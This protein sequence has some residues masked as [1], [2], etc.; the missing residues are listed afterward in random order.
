MTKSDQLSA[1]DLA[2]SSAGIPLPQ[3]IPAPSHPTL[4]RPT[5]LH[6]P[7]P[8]HPTPFHPA[9]HP[10][11]THAH[12]DFDPPFPSHS[13]LGAAATN[14]REECVCGHRRVTQLTYY[15]LPTYLLTTYLLPTYLLATTYYLLP[16][17]YLPTYLS[18]YYL[19]TTVY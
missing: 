12:S 7:V 4:P 2:C 11:P 17:T 9:P 15:L 18:A 3:H 10:N 19:P 8:I 14:G 5:A 16:T 6:L 1:E 13:D